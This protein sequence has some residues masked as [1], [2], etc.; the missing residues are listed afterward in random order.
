MEYQESNERIQVHK[1]MF[2]KSNDIIDL[3]TFIYCNENGILDP[4]T[5]L[6][7]SILA[8]KNDFVDRGN[9]MIVDVMIGT[10]TEYL[11]A[12]EV[13]EED[14]AIKFPIDLLNSLET[15]G[16]PA[17]KIKLKLGCSIILIRNLN[18][19][20]GLSNGTKLIVTKL[21]PHLIE[22][23]FAVGLKVGRA[24]IPRISIIP[25]D[26]SSTDGLYH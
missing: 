15:S 24:F 13:I 12:D 3:I 17:H 10:A 16:S 21:M 22:A 8:P 14:N 9:S 2:L 6:E 1:E 26:S 18:S 11:S 20:A 23:E 7:N 4:I 19:S 5:Y 25:T